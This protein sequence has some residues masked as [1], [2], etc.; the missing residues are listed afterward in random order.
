MS[1]P[2]HKDQAM[3]RVTHKPA[4]TLVG[5]SVPQNFTKP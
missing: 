4:I 3:N 1:V 5:L 2:D